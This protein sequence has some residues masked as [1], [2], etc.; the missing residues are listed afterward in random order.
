MLDTVL[1]C[2]FIALLATGVVAMA[3]ES[4]IPPEQFA[5]L[6]WEGTPGDPAV[7][8]E[9]RQ[10]GFNLAGFVAPADLDAVQAAGLK[11]IVS[12]GLCHVGDAE[13]SLDDAEITR[14]VEEVVAKTK[15]HPAV[16]GY[17]LRDEPSSAPFP[18]LGKWAA[19]FQKAAPQAVPYINLLPNYAS[20]EQLGAANYDE[21]L[22]KFVATVRPRFVS[23]DH[24][25]LMDDGSLSGGYFQN[26][27]AVRRVALQSGLPFWNTVL[28]NSHFPS[29]PAEGGLRLQAYTTL[30]YGARGI[31]YYTYFT[32]FAPRV[33]SYRLAP[34]EQLGSR[35]VTRHMLRSVNLQIQEL[36]PTYITLKSVNVFHHPNVPD[37][38]RGLDS[39]VHLTDLQGGDLMAGEFEG[40]AGEPYVL[41]VN[42]GLHRS[43]AFGITPKAEGNVEVISAYTG[44]PTPFTGEQV[45]LEAGQGML[46]RLGR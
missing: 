3:Q 23:Y 37:G 16:Y 39:S 33:G 18:G 21:Y 25:A 22:E 15:G 26:L 46:L 31:S 27:E 36:V 12:D 2:L 7:L 42:K 24:Y 10:C 8:D 4:P 5:I 30:A 17:Y 28:P 14:R 32:Y 9:I 6:P 45:W 1:P 40:P 35:A 43:T 34:I 19:A 13:A 11:A 44:Q 41:V 20:P 38:C 29:E